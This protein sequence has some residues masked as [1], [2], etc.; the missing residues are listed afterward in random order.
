MNQNLKYKLISFAF[1][2]SH[3]LLLVLLVIHI[4]SQ[5]LAEFF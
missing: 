2:F 1:Y 3:L 4:Y 5:L